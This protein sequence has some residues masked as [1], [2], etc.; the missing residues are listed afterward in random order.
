MGGRNMQDMDDT[1]TP[2]RSRRWNHICGPVLVE[3]FLAIGK[4]SWSLDNWVLHLH[5]HLIGALLIKFGLGNVV[6]FNFP[7]RSSISLKEID[8]T[9]L[10]FR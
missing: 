2:G 7:L 3:S 5:A 9:K 8:A 10:A 1:C 6:K 4:S